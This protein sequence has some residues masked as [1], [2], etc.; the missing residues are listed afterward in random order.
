MLLLVHVGPV[1]ASSSHTDKLLKQLIKIENTTQV[2]QQDNAN[3]S[4]TKLNLMTFEINNINS[5]LKIL[6]AAQTVSINGTLV[7]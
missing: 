5:E 4:Q 2:L 1:L 6:V 7:H 3:L